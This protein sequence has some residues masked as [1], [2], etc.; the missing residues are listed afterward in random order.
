MGADRFENNS[1]QHTDGDGD[2]WGDNSSGTDGDGC[3]EIWGNSTQ[4]GLLGCIDSDGD[5]WAD[6]IDWDV[7]DT[8]QWADDD[9]DSYGDNP[10]GT[11]GDA[12]PGEWGNS[13]EGGIL[14]CLDSD[15]DGWG[16]V[17]DWSSSDASQWADSDSDGYGDESTGTQGDDCNSTWGN[18]TENGT[19]GCID[20]DGDGW[21]DIDD[22]SITDASQWIDDDGDD[23]GD[24][25]NGTNGDSCPG[26]WGNST[27][28]GVLGCLDSDGDDWADIVDA[29]INESSQWADWD[30][31][32]YGD[33]QNGSNADDCPEQFGVSYLD[34][35]GCADW[36]ADGVSNP[37]DP[38][39]LD[40]SLA[41][42][43]DGDNIDNSIDN[44]PSTSN[45]NQEDY[46]FDQIGDVCD[47]DD[48]GDS[49][50]NTEDLC[51]MGEK[52]WLS[53]PEVDVDSDGCR[54]LTEDDDDDGDGIKDGE[55]LCTSS[56]NTYTG[57]V[58]SNGT[59]NS[60]IATDWDEDGCEDA[61]TED[62][63]DDNDGIVDVIDQCPHG[64]SSWRSTDTTDEDANGCE[65]TT[66]DLDEDN[67]ID[68]FDQCPN[69]A[70]HSEVD[71]KGCSLVQIQD[72]L[73]Q[74]ENNQEQLKSFL[75]RVSSGDFEAISILLAIFVPISGLLL[76]AIYHLSHRAYIRKLRKLILSAE[77]I[78]QLHEARALLRKSVSD[79]RLT[80]SQYSLL[81]E[82]INV[83]LEKLASTV[84]DDTLQKSDTAR[85]LR[86]AEWN[87]TVT[88][89]LRDD[90]YR[91]DDE[92]VEWWED[93]KKLWW[94]RKPGDDRWSKWIE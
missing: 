32:G 84:A 21:A 59:G 75:N 15:G 47:D 69:T 37:N 45:V 17:A 51:Q 28:G 85:N 44:C 7:S 49:I 9:S 25:P 12:C 26:V 93:E 73:Q 20:T 41:I 35:L 87:K 33:N 18:S 24:N 70:N 19:L 94:Y 80:E 53:A 61:T 86:K 22:W 1:D 56:V 38:A 57:W 62:L 10:N 68:K 77:E 92:G 11:N 3:P 48:D 42:D 65:D 71:D 13:T 83:Q 55:D 81:N 63:D 6:T 82:E 5:D 23:S 29:F 39:P 34:V 74:S 16:D 90:S 4:G 14:G 76:T 30:G 60:S 79:E 67:V 2:G 64:P 27:G 88:K 66:Q 78:E 31:D 36:D 8:T 58:S 40:A 54:D 46:D 91:V 89:V 50:P 43:D 52:N 72:K